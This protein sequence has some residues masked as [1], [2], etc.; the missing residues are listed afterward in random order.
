VHDFSRA[1]KTPIK[2]RASAPAI[3]IQQ[4]LTV[5]DSCEAVSQARFV[6]TARL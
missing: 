3:F 5:L 1:E 6:T 4:N 2:P